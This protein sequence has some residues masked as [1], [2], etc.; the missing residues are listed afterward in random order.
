M[1][2]RRTGMGVAAALVGAA[3]AGQW[4]GR[5]AGSSRGERHTLLPGDELVAARPW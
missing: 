2:G 5:T 1:G 4:L 3:A